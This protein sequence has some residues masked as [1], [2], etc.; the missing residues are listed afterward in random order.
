MAGSSDDGRAGSS[1]KPEGYSLRDRERHT[2]IM[3]SS[4]SPGIH[5]VDE[6]EQVLFPQSGHAGRL[7][8]KYWHLT[9]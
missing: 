4:I 5:Q 8:R 2:D 7:W 9:D 6:G 3:N 1:S